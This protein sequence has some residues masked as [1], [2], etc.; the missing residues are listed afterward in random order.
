MIIVLELG[1]PEDICIV[2]SE[3]SIKNV[4]PMLY[5]LSA[6]LLSFLLVIHRPHPD[7]YYF[8]QTIKLPSWPKSPDQSNRSIGWKNKSTW[9]YIFFSFIIYNTHMVD[10]I[11]IHIASTKYVV[12][13]KKYILAMAAFLYILICL[14]HAQVPV[15][16]YSVSLFLQVPSTCSFIQ[17]EPS[18][19]AFPSL[20]T[21]LLLLPTPSQYDLGLERKSTAASHNNHHNLCQ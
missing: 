6:S 11:K 8:L 20:P 16:Q 3:C 5:K 7:P 18:H 10:Y 15:A 1:F 14:Y 4:I 19:S 9:W 2:S 21:C 17:Q 12:I 13:D